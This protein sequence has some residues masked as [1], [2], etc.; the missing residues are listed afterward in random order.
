MELAQESGWLVVDAFNVMVHLFTSE[1]RRK[2][3]LERLW[4]DAVEI[5]IPSL[6]AVPQVAAPKAPKKAPAKKAAPKKTPAKAA[7]KKAKRKN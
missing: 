2:Y 7:G 1:Q 3:Q 4:K 6:L 5:S